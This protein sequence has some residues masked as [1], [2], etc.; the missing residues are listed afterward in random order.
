M[1]RT[2]LHRPCIPY[3]KTYKTSDMETVLLKQTFANGTTQKRKCL[4]FSGEQGAEGLLQ[5]KER[6]DKVCEQL[7]FDTGEE[8][9][10]NFSQVLSD[11]AEASWSN[12]VDNINENDQTVAR[13]T[14]EYTTL[15]E[16][17]ATNRGRDFMKDY[18]LSGEVQK[19][20]DTDCREHAERIQTMIRYTNRLQGNTPQMNEEDEKNCVFKS[21]PPS[22]QEEYELSGRDYHTQSIAEIVDYF[23]TLK[24]KKDKDEL[25][26]RNR[27]GRAP[28]QYRGGYGGRGRGTG[29]RS[30]GR[31]YHPYPQ[32]Y[33]GSRNL[34]MSYQ[35][36]GDQTY[37]GNYQGR[38]QRIDYDNPRGFGRGRQGRNSPGRYA[39]PRGYTPQRGTQ[40]QPSSQRGRAPYNEGNR[41]FQG[42][43]GPPAANDGQNYYQERRQQD[44]RPVPPARRE[45][46]RPRAI[47]GHHFDA[48]LIS[49]LN[50]EDHMPSPQYFISDD[51]DY[52]MY[53]PHAEYT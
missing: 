22:W 16:R 10:D 52:N 45:N 41:G 3:V 6:F 31:G 1:L 8:L 21:Y 40:F 35:Y 19:K 38:Y 12:L 11:N 13:F 7:R 18:L 28:M 26:K 17:Y 9:F 43:N 34:Q 25:T 39:N 24:V 42:G 37:S 44:R 32:Q 29:R 27:A 47:E 49:Q 23:S 51:P 53:G 36:R 4:V 30:G 48:D 15:L 5:T 14:Q 46:N 20:H 33:V 2:S 50:D